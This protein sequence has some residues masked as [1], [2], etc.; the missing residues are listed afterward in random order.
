MVKPSLAPINS[1]SRESVRFSWYVPRQMAKVRCSGRPSMPAWIEVNAQ[2]SAQTSQARQAPDS[3][4][5][6]LAG[7]GL[8]FVQALK[9]PRRQA[10][11]SPEQAEQVAPSAPHASALRPGWQAPFSSQHP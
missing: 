1:T 11:V 6:E 2:P 5:T 7:H 3:A 10:G 9:T 4:Q 8:T